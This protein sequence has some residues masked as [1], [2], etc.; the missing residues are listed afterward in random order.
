M[1]DRLRIQRRKAEG[2]LNLPSCYDLIMTQLIFIQQAAIL[3]LGFIL[4]LD[5]NKL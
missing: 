4:F 2:D 5:K 1:S 3:M